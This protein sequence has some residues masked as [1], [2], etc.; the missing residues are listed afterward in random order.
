MSIHEHQ[1][2]TRTERLIDA[3]E[4]NT[5]T[6]IKQNKALSKNTAAMEALNKQLMAMNNGFGADVAPA[7]P[8]E[9]L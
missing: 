3:M 4:N 5:K 6:L 7:D 2:K 1:A 9:E 8:L